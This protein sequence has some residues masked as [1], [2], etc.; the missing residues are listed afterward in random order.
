MPKFFHSRQAQKD[1]DEI[2]HYFAL[3]NTRAADK[4]IDTIAEKC[5]RLS[6]APD[7]GEKRPDL[8]DDLRCFSAGNYV[9]FFRGISK[10][11]EIVR[12]LHGARDVN[13]LF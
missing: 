10:G 1:L 13:G 7:M 4:L 5:A 2:W 8:G 11:I 9:I 6:V 3:D 12:V